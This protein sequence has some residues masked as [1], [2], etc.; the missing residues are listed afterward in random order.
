M[1]DETCTRCGADLDALPLE[2]HY[3]LDGNAYCA[4]CEPSDEDAD[5]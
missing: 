1:P 4:A 2:P 5:A 3:D